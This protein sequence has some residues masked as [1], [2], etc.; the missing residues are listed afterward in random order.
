LLEQEQYSYYVISAKQFHL[1][2]L[3]LIQTTNNIDFSAYAQEKKNSNS[4]LSNF[5]LPDVKT[6]LNGN[7]LAILYIA[8]TKLYL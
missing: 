5:H 3:K 2:F 8:H 4:A 7:L 1:K 6:T